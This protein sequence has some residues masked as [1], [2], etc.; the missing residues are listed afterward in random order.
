MGVVRSDGWAMQAGDAQGRL[1]QSRQ[2]AC[3]AWTAVE[4]ACGVWGIG[5][6]L[7]SQR[8]QSTRLCIVLLDA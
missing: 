3:C 5:M 6:G 8:V 7:A 2:G 4:G 1:P